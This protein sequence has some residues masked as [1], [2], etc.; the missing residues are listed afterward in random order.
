M[1]SCPS[2]T[3][4]TGWAQ[5]PPMVSVGQAGS[6]QSPKHLPTAVSCPQMTGVCPRPTPP[7]R[8]GHYARGCVAPRLWAPWKCLPRREGYHLL[9]HQLDPW[10]VSP[11]AQLIPSVQRHPK[12]AH[13]SPPRTPARCCPGSSPRPPALP[14]TLL[15]LPIWAA[16]GF[17]KSSCDPPQPNRK[18]TPTPCQ[19]LAPSWPSRCPHPYRSSGPSR[20]VWSH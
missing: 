8:D 5:V 2:H 4:S 20:S 9:G 17:S 6:Q 10:P 19:D 16:G 11:S 1:C 12:S 18:K 13:L 3:A 14:P 7:T 15:Q